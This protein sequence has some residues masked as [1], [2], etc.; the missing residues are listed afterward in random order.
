MTQQILDTLNNLQ[1]EQ[2]TQIKHVNFQQS[3]T[4]PSISGE[5]LYIY[6]YDGSNNPLKGN[7]NLNQFPN[8]RTI[9]FNNNFR[10]FLETLDISE[11]TQLNRIILLRQHNTPNLSYRA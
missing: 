10:P 3:N 1:P 9:T 8:L 5:V 11:N 4:Q 6:D 2:K 7:L